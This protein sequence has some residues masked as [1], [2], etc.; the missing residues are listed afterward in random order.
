MSFDKFTSKNEKNYKSKIKLKYKMLFVPF[1]A[2]LAFVILF[3]MFYSFSKG[4][5][6]IITHAETLNLSSELE[7][8][9]TEVQRAM[10]DAVAAE[11]QEELSIADTLY[12]R[13]LEQLEHAKANPFFPTDDVDFIELEFKDYYAFARKTTE[14]LIET[15][16]FDDEELLN[17]IEEMQTRLNVIKEKLQSTTTI[18]NAKVYEAFNETLSIRKRAKNTTRSVLVLCALILGGYTFFLSR[19]ITSSI[20]EMIE[21]TNNFAEGN[22]DETIHVKTH[23]EIGDLGYAIN[24]MMGKIKRQDILKSGKEELNIQMRGEPELSKLAHNVINCLARY[25]DA[26]IGAIYLVNGD[27][28]LSLVGSYAYPHQNGK[29]AADDTRHDRAEKISA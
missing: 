11:D 6:K 29:K 28:A 10:M 12:S 19:S 26:Q 25:L 4:Y 16:S 20:N 8:S 21:I 5:E 22:T 1:L 17:N 3:G 27:N 18:A 7:K 14:A 24:E 2:V 15:G 9:L 23:D 13:F